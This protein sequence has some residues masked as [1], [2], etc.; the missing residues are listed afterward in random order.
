MVVSEGCTP[1][2]FSVR[3]TARLRVFTVLFLLGGIDL[4]RGNHQ[5]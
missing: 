1:K 3:I 4:H 2:L 5:S